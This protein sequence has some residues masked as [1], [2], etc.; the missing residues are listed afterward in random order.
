MTA[1]D[2]NA[3]TDTAKTAIL[4]VAN[5]IADDILSGK[6]AAESEPDDDD[7]AESERAQP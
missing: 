2:L 1:L 7:D 6:L 3:K 4:L 5:H